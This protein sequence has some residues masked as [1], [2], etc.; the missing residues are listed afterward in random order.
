MKWIF[1]IISWENCDCIFESVQFVRK[2]RRRGD[3]SNNMK[4]VIKKKN[5]KIRSARICID[6]LKGEGKHRTENLRREKKKYPINTILKNQYLQYKNKI[7]TWKKKSILCVVSFMN[8]QADCA[9]GALIPTLLSRAII[10]HV[11]TSLHTRPPNTGNW[12]FTIRLCINFSNACKACIRNNEFPLNPWNDEARGLKK[13]F[14]Q[15]VQVTT[16]LPWYNNSKDR[17]VSV[18]GIF[19]VNVSKWIIKTEL[20]NESL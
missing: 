14:R 8:R 15:A 10:L 2:Y 19:V 11:H 4:L 17:R 6:I 20:S 1:A 13:I 9:M 12:L 5:C 3:R 18:R 7:C 16:Y